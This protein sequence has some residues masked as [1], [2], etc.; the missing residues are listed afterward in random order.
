MLKMIRDKIPKTRSRE[1]D[2]A[3]ALRWLIGIFKVGRPVRT[4]HTSHATRWSFHGGVGWMR[5]R[6]AVWEIHFERR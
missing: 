3:Y 2:E 1:R 4:D 5:D 6:G